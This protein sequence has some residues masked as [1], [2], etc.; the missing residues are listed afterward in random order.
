M[1]RYGI[2]WSSS[3]SNLAVAPSETSRPA[4]ASVGSIPEPGAHNPMGPLDAA[5]NP[6]FIAHQQSSSSRP[7]G[8]K[9]SGG[10]HNGIGA[11]SSRLTPPNAQ[12]QISSR[13]IGTGRYGDGAHNE[14]GP[15]DSACSLSLI[16]Q[17][18]PSRPVGGRRCFD[19][20]HDELPGLADSARSPS[21]IEGQL[22][23]WL[24][25]RRR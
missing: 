3:S 4:D 13:P 12:Q 9:N 22:P 5:L 24:V 23:S 15:A 8:R 19:D 6:L 2:T 7:P 10:A 21:F 16:A 11:G 17:L 25:G 18:C 14:L 20:A 1:L